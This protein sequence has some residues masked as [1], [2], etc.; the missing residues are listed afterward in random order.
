[1]NRESIR[2]LLTQPFNL[3]AATTIEPLQ[4]G[5]VNSIYKLSD[6]NRQYAVKWI[7]DDGFSG[8][9]RFHQ[10]VLQEQLATRGIAPKPVWLSDDERVWVEQW[11]HSNNRSPSSREA[12]VVLLAKV[13]ACVHQ[14]PITARPLHLVERWE[15]YIY[16]AN[17]NA[18]HALVH[19]ANRLVETYHLDKPNDDLLALCHNDLHRDHVIDPDAPVIV[20]WEY[21][22]MGNR[23]F[24][25]ASCA[26]INQMSDEESTALCLT[27]AQTAEVD[28]EW[29]E[30]QFIEQSQVVKLTNQLWQAALEATLS[31]VAQPPALLEPGY[32]G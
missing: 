13:L 25:L 23:F 14:Q 17:L 8:I 19:E 29:V 24:D 20:D 18:S 10:F 12:D 15:H 2:T 27:Y 5:E 1:M 3:S 9:N 4:G 32:I 6:G 31:D 21:S 26:L 28:G 7:G 30:Q 16:K 11:V 22:A